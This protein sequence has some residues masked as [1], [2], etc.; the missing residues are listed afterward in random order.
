MHNIEERNS[1][2]PEGI[3]LEEGDL[4]VKQKHEASQLFTKSESVFLKSL[5][6]IGYTKLVEGHIK[7]VMRKCLK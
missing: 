7:S 1:S 5:L 2:L 4:S 3:N 6:D